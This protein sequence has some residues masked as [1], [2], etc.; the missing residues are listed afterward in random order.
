VSSYVFIFH[1]LTDI[2]EELLAYLNKSHVDNMEYILACYQSQIDGFD[3]SI[4]MQGISTAGNTKKHWRNL[5]RADAEQVANHIA[6]DEDEDEDGDSDA[7]SRGDLLF[8]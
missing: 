6:T 7:R 5:V 4:V 2:L 8:V 1:Q 3:T